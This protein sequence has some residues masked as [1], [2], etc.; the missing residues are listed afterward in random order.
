MTAP[1]VVVLALLALIP[2]ESAP[3]SRP[4]SRPASVD[5]L[6]AAL[7]EARAKRGD[8]RA[9]RSEV[10]QAVYTPQ[11]AKPLRS[12]GTLW[13]QAPDRFRLELVRPRR[14]CIVLKG[15]S[16][17]SF[18]GDDPKPVASGSG[19]SLSREITELLSLADTPEHLRDLARHRRVDGT[20]SAEDVE[21]K[22][23]PLG[24]DEKILER[25]V[26]VMLRVRRSDGE[27]RA[28]LLAAEGGDRTEFLIGAGE[29]LQ[30]L[31]DSLFQI[32]RFIPAAK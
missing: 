29:R 18:R 12:E 16:F 4:A 8:K 10:V 24:K 30:D 5:E 11:L 6:V 19:G 32:D 25:Y 9:F 3:A 22:L 20:L 17:A 23:F 21:V 14:S 28:L 2:Q 1:V 31:Q 27:P 7:A 26:E 13:F 15:E